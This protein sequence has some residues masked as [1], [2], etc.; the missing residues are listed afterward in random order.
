MQIE[1]R[2][3]PALGSLQALIDEGRMSS[4]DF[5]FLG[6]FMASD[7]SPCDG[8]TALTEHLAGPQGVLPLSSTC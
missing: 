2:M 3:G 8:S 7:E 1:E 5:A 6:M 4:F